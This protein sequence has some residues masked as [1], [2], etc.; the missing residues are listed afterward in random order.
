[1]ISKFERFGLGFGILTLVAAAGTATATT[2]SGGACHEAAGDAEAPATL[3]IVGTVRDFRER[4]VTG[5][6]PDF[7]RAPTAGFGCYYEMVADT[8]DADGKPAHRSGGKK[9][10]SH[11]R[12]G[13][14]QNILTRPYIA[15]RS[16]DVAAS[17]AS[18]VGGAMTSAE[19]FGQW[20]RDVP[21]TNMSAPLPITLVRNTSGVYVFDD[22]SDP[23]FTSRGGFFPINGELF[24]NSAGGTKNFH[25]TYELRTNFTYEEGAGQTFKFTGDDDVWVFIDGKL[26]I[27]LGGVHGAVS[28]NIELDRLEWLADGQVYSLDFFFAERHRTQSNCRI[29]TNMALRN[30]EVPET[31][32]MHD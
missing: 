20:Y 9:V 21:G 3:T 13:A 29:E 14:G 6:H 18:T 22:K 5:G 11:A 16:G 27:D 28:Q 8:L 12:N 31:S 4:S 30:V 17:T 24:G 26:V 1:M 7:E 23:V 10:S 25:F 19:S 15:A 2:G 32:A